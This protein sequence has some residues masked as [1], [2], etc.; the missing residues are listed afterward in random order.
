MKRLLPVFIFVV[1]LF[2]ATSFAVSAQTPTTAV[3][4]SAAPTS[5]PAE[6]QGKW[7]SDPEVTFVGKAATR[8]NDFLNWTLQNYDWIQFKSGEPHPLLN[9]WMLVAGTVFAVLLLFILG[10]AFVMVVTRGQNLTIW[11]FVKRFVFVAILIVMSFALVQ[12]LYVIGD[13][14]QGWLLRPDGPRG[15]LISSKDLLYIDFNYAF[16][17]YRLAG[18]ENDESAF[19]S[20]LLVKLTAITYYVMSGILLIRKIILWF[21]LI[22]SPVF[23][24][25]LFF[26]PVRNTAKIWIGEFFRWLL[27]APLFALFLH[28]LVRMWRER[29][30]LPFDFAKAGVDVVYPTAI[31]I[32]LGGPGQAIS[33]NNS[34]NL[35]DT[36]AQYVVALL[37]LWVVILLPFLL[38]R[39]F[40][41]YLN[42]INIP[43]NAWIRQ[44][45]NKNLGFLNPR[46]PIPP[47]VPPTPPPGKVFPAGLA[48][49]LPFT[50]GEAQRITDVRTNSMTSSSISKIQST[51]EIL[52]NVNISIPK[53]VDIARYEKS[54]ISTDTSSREVVSNFHETLEKIANPRT[55]S[56]PI[57]REKFQQVH[58]K[59]VE[60]KEK[61]N[62]VASSILNATDVVAKQS[63]QKTMAAGSS[64]QV[65]SRDSSGKPIIGQTAPALPVVNRVQQVSI[66]DYEEVR[67]MWVDNY[68]NLEPPRD[69]NGQQVDRGEWIQ[70]DIDKVN[71]AISL[72]SSVDPKK[73]NEGME[74]VGNILPFL[75]MGGFSKS[76]VITYLKAK[77]EAAKSVR[78]QVAKKQEEEDT[79]LDAQQGSQT[80]E[81]KMAASQEVNP[82]EKTSNEPKNLEDMPEY[83]GSDEVGKK[84]PE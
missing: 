23:P 24:L 48:R 73:V 42:S 77:L 14:I 51:N 61:G 80:E 59:L 54:M 82:N 16:S 6:I 65:I 34:V 69:L 28:G 47:P 8:A 41:D 56:T 45:F 4:T 66:E 58:E 13:Y 70:N 10:S 44:T 83:G 40:L 60:Q 25:L 63:T 20:L 75:L 52:R 38:L 26:R 64:G 79:V 33:I 32:L 78:D 76:E 11:I 72:M 37:M 36:F 57:E 39:I 74:I 53:M 62:P 29:I 9:Y 7:I 43:Q 18:A 19:I 46:N 31:N 30:P 35:R 2:Y 81:K 12:F 67:K 17:G 55:V 27:Y 3:P 22:V 15:N 21:F 49:Q 1:S 50:R 71:E 68:E 5:V 84:L